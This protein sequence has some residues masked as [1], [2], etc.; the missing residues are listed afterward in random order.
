VMHLATAEAFASPE[1][2]DN[3]FQQRFYPLLASSY[4]S[5]FDDMRARAPCITTSHSVRFLKLCPQLNWKNVEYN[6]SGEGCAGATRAMCVG[7]RFPGE[8]NRAKLVAVS[9]E[10]GRMTHNHPT[11]FLGSLTSALF[12]AYAVEGVSLVEWGRKMVDDVLPVAYNYLQE[13]SRDWENYQ[14]DLNNFE[15]KWKDY[16]LLRGISDTEVKP[17][18][19]RD[20]DIFA[21]DRFYKSISRSGCAGASGDDSVMIAYDALLG[22]KGNWGELVKR[23]IIHGGDTTSTGIIAA[24]WFGAV[25]GV[26]SIPKQTYEKLEYRKRAELLGEQLYHLSPFNREPI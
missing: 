4:V 5:C 25:Y 19:P 3:D 17:I 15:D 14:L 10:S 11:G 12:T 6:S 26:N 23:G 2:S 20:F 13:N 1:S 9:I 22:S 21:R 16:L 8:M 24:A 7:L 18:F